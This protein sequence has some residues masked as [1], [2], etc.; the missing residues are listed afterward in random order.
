MSLTYHYGR[1]LFYGVPNAS[2]LKVLAKVQI[3]NVRTD[4]GAQEAGS[5]RGDPQVVPRGN[6]PDPGAVAAEGH[7]ALRGP[8]KQRLPNSA[9]VFKIPP[10]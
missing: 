9:P 7:P 1:F 6:G 3:R 8:A 4:G 10:I 2:V 5:L